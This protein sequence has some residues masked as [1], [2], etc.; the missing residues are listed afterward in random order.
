MLTGSSSLIYILEN[1]P[2]LRLMI[3]SDFLKTARSWTTNAMSTRAAQIVKD[4]AKLVA[5]PNTDAK[6]GPRI[7]PNPNAPVLIADK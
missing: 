3:S 7:E 1:C 4:Q 6:I 2:S 5:V